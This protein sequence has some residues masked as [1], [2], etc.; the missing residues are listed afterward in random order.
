MLLSAL[1]KYNGAPLQVN[2]FDWEGGG[3]VHAESGRLHDHGE[4]VSLRVEPPPGKFASD[5]ALNGDVELSSDLPSLQALDPV[6]T[7]LIVEV[8]GT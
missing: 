7:E 2:G 4:R 6:V 8:P 3:V 5:P 1:V